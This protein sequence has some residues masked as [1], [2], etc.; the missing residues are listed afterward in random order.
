MKVSWMVGLH[1][2]AVAVAAR[3]IAA[4]NT[5]LIKD[6]DGNTVGVLVICSSCQ[7]SDG[8][9]K[10]CQ[11]GVQEGWLNGKPCGKCMLVGN[12]GQGLHH[13]YDL[14]FTGKLVDTTG[15]P[16]KDRFV[17]LF[18]PNGW[19]VRTRSGDDGG[20]RLM[21][22]ATESRKSRNP[23]LVDLGTRVD[24]QPGKEAYSLYAL[25]ESYRPCAPTAATPAQQKDRQTLGH[26]PRSKKQ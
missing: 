9:A 15:A 21:L 3:V 22:G 19:T 24:A 4:E 16:R 12:A 14:H 5:Q 26:K 6:A 11:T 18:L 7:S 1:I 17:S 8:S 25:P 10:D 23:L 2:V 13:A 20:F